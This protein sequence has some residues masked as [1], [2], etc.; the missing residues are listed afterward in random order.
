MHKIKCSECGEDTEVPFK[1]IEGRPVY[2]RE[3]Y[4]KRKK[5]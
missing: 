5:Y 3:C 2:C 4:Q 1:P